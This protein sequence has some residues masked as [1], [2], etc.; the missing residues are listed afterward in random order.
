MGIAQTIGEAPKSESEHIEGSPFYMSP[1]QTRA[2]ELDW[3]SDQYSLGATLYNM[4]VG[5]PPFD[6]RDIMRIVEMHTDTPVPSPKKR[7]PESNVSPETVKLMKKMMAKTP[8][9][10]FKSWGELQKRI[11]SILRQSKKSSKSSKSKVGTQTTSIKSQPLPTGKG[12]RKSSPRRPV[13]I[14]KRNSTL[15]LINTFIILAII[16]GAAFFGIRLMVEAKAKKAYVNAVNYLKSPNYDYNYAVTLFEN[17][18]NVAGNFFVGSGIK[19]QIVSESRTQRAKLGVL[20][21][22]KKAFDKSFDEAAA[23]YATAVKLIKEKRYGNALSAANKAFKA[24]KQLKP[25]TDLDKEKTDTL[26]KNL[27]ILRNRLYQIVKKKK[28]R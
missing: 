5:V 21:D 15:A 4:V 17:A 6:H 26:S 3:S 20:I 2:E 11:K 7:N 8:G 19:K 12:R 22:E 13:V 25:P 10:R 24:M 27:K 28:R 23:F 18:E 9:E 16:C 1:E 14:K